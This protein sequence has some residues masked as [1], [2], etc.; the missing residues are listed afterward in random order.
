MYGQLLGKGKFGEVHLGRHLET[1][2][3]VAIKRV[4]KAKLIEYNMVERFIQEIK[5]HSSM[6]H[7]NIVRLY[8]FFEEKDYICLVMEYLNGGTLFDYLNEVGSLSQKE[9]IP[10]LR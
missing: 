3:I 7:P 9:A 4:S 10:F 1:G 5:L 2:F 8:T 6:D